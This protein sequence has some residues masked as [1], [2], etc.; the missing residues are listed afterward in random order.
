MADDLQAG[1]LEGLKELFEGNLTSSQ[2]LDLV[3]EIAMQTCY[4]LPGL[5]A[6]T[7]KIE[8]R[9]EMAHHCLVNGGR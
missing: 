2:Q 6:D 8:K 5:N 7:G 4:D 3:A 1:G 9:T